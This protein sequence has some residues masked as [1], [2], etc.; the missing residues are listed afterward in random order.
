MQ[1]TL[2]SDR[3]I[4]GI[5]LHSGALVRMVLRPAAPD[6]G[7]VFRRV[8]CPAGRNEIAVSPAN[9]VEASLCTVLRNAHDVQISTVEHLLAALHGCGIHNALI[10]ID[11]PEV[12]ILDGSAAP[13][14]AHILATGLRRQ[15][16]PLKV[17]RI[18]KPVEVSRNGAVARLLP[19]SSLQIAFE[20]D[21]DDAAIGHQA[22]AFDMANGAFL[23]E[24]S[25]CRTFCR[26]A[27]VE[28]MQQNG[29]ALGGTLDNA[30]VFDGGRVLTPGGLR[31]PDEP[32]RHKMLDAMGDLYVMGRPLVGR[33]EG[34]R[35]GHALTGLLLQKLCATPD[36]YEI[37]TCDLSQRIRLPGAGIS[38]RDLPLSA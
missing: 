32:V 31:R 22:R 23:R 2:S 8:D 28:T 10:E 29:L 6:T 15:D 13:F 25:D 12:P 18:L 38:L 20:I 35:A 16:A 34:V 21:F 4:K 7:I 1:T 30:V 11:G 37:A 9:W 24:L 19:A 36:A 5:G 3:Q 33:Y 26:R 17:A 27:D 14:V